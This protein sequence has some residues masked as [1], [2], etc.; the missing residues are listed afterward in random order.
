MVA[1]E[2]PRLIVVAGPNGSGKTSITEQLLRHAWM[3]GCVYV[4]PDFIARDEFGDWNSPDI[5]L[6][7]ALRA[8]EIRENCLHQGRSLAFE[9]VLSSPDKV[10]FMSR[11]KAAGFFVR[12]FFVGTDDPSINAKRVALRVMEGGHDV[13][14]PKIISRYTKS[15]AQCSIAAAVSD[16]AYLYDNSVDNAKARLLYRVSDASVVKTYAAINPWAE[17]IASQLK[18]EKF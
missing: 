15:M 11:A 2:K 9:T 14:I 13:P 18:T 17:E 7:A 4:N 6:K 10:A 3:D 8:E 1:S 5:V 12:L 16:R